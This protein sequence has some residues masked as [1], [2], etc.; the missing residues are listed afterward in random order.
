M[1]QTL[2]QF[3]QQRWCAL[4]SAAGDR[5]DEDMV[6]QGEILG[7]NF[8]RVVLYEDHYLRG[9]AEGEIMQLFQSGV[10]NGK[11]VREALQVIGWKNAIEQVL[12]SAQPGELWLVQADTIAETVSYMKSLQVSNRVLRE[13]TMKEA[14]EGPSIAPTNVP[15]QTPVTKATAKM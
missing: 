4:Y 14:L 2:Q 1:L 3:P 12:Q 10:N 9:R 15:G 8:D 5:R 13:I 11:R 6:R 7:D